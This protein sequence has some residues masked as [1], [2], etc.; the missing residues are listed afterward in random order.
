MAGVVGLEFTRRLGIVD[1]LG[2]E[3]RGI[4]TRDCR[5]TGVG[6]VLVGEVFVEIGDGARTYSRLLPKEVYPN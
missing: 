3:T 2:P 5:R 4:N 1:A 6:D